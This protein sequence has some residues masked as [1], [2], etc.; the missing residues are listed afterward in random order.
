[1]INDLRNGSFER[2]T[3]DFWTLITGTEF[4][5]STIEKV[6]GLYSGKVKASAGGSAFIQN[7][8]YISV[9]GS[10]IIR[11]KGSFFAKG[12]ALYRIYY[13]EYDDDMSLIQETTKGGALVG[14][15]WEEQ[16]V[17]VILHNET[18]YIKMKVAIVNSDANEDVY[19]DNIR[20][21]LLN[22]SK[23]SVKYD[24]L[25]NIINETTKHT[26]V[27]SEFFTGIWKEAEYFFDLTSF[28]ETVGANPV[29]IDVKIESYDPETDT[30]RDAMVFQ[31]KS[32]PA[33]GSVTTREYK[34]LVGGL[35]WK[36]RVSYTTAG[37]GTIGDCDFKVGVVYKR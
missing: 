37:A 12:A 9:Q 34:R 5:A 19:F 1:M 20:L 2:G 14:D 18:S 3:I 10:D 25:I 13:L 11:C 7:N 6:R 21:E 35:G 24:V 22:G 31:Q 33:S 15:L 4:A 36:Q 26:V 28:T 30:W 23:Y 17:Y 16:E 32:C 27:G 8:D 29:T